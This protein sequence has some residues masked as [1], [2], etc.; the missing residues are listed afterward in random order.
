ME[1][2]NIR[3]LID[4]ETSINKSSFT[5]FHSEEDAE[6]SVDKETRERLIFKILMGLGEEIALLS[7]ILTQ[8][9]DANQVLSSSCE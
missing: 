9:N 3:K 1:F 8:L 6:D 7:D 2:K 5:C 4:F